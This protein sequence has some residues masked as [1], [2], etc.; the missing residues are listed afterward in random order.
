[1]FGGLLLEASVSLAA[2]MIAAGLVY[3]WVHEQRQRDAVIKLVTVGYSAVV[4]FVLI[5][6]WWNKLQRRAAGLAASQ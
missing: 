3:K 2:L 6:E 1:M 5:D 4:G